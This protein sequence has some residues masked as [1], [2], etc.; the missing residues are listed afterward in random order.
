MSESKPTD[1]EQQ[2]P[3]SG[4]ES[5]AEIVA[6]SV[7]DLAAMAGNAAGAA[8]EALGATDKESQNAESELESLRMKLTES[9][10]EVLRVQADM[11]NFRKRTRRDTQDQIRYAALPLVTELIEV[12]DNLQRGIESAEAGQSGDGLLEGVK[13]VAQQLNDLLTA[14]GCEKINAVGQAFDPNCHEAIQ[15]QPSDEFEA[16]TVS[17]ETRTGYR[18]HERVIRPAQVFVSTGPKSES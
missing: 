16:N 12:I 6:A 5:A 10:K 13:M 14:N 4:L 17:M 1:D 18:L 2:E 9:E 15:M 3:A 8:A 7:E 11:E